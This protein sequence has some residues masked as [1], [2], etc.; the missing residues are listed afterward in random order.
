MF[1]RNDD[2]NERRDYRNVAPPAD[3]NKKQPYVDVSQIKPNPGFGNLGRKRT[4]NF[5]DEYFE[6]DDDQP[7]FVADEDSQ[8]ATKEEDEDEEDPLDAFMAGIETEV[9][10]V[11]KKSTIEPK[12]A[13]MSSKKDIKVLKGVRGDIEEEDTEEAYYKYMQENPNAGL[14]SALGDSDA[15]KTRAAPE[16]NTMP[17]ETRF[18]SRERT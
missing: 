1:R 10:A 9:K 2:S 17:T 13:R 16:L 8:E 11:S 7:N 5:D 12:A 4:A 6:D 3:L 18:M 14:N 15:R